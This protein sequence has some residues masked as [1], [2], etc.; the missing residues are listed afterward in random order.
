MGFGP[1]EQQPE[2]F[3][4]TVESFLGEGGTYLQPRAVIE[5]LPGVPAGATAAGREAMGA[6]RFPGAHAGPGGNGPIHCNARRDRRPGR[7]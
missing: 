4:P 1:D 5:N 6:F 7:D 2:A 3:Y